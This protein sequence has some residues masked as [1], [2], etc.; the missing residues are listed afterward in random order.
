M[1]MKYKVQVQVQVL[2]AATVVMGVIIEKWFS[3]VAVYT[4][5]LL[6]T[7]LYYFFSPQSDLLLW[8]MK[9]CIWLNE[10]GHRCENN[11]VHVAWFLA[12]LHVDKTTLIHVL[13]VLNKVRGK[14]VKRG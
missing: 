12:I 9:K 13:P 3:T 4:T 14:Y 7:S 5:T 8:L 2:V 11:S 10:T 1:V 6:H